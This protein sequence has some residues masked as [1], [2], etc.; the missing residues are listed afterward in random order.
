MSDK[1]YFITYRYIRPRDFDTVGNDIKDNMNG[2]TIRAFVDYETRVVSTVFSICR[3][4]NFH[5]KS[6]RLLSTLS[7]KEFIFNY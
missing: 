2:I 4:E 6:G 3:N 5:K 1:E 7:E